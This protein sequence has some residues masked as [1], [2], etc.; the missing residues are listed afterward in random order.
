MTFFEQ[1]IERLKATQGDTHA[2]CAVAAEFLLL[3]QPEPEREQLRA[4]LDAAAVLRWFD[5]SFLGKML[6]IA[7]ADA[8]KRFDALKALPFVERYRRGEAD[9]RNVHE[10]TRLGWRKEL[11]RANCARFRFLSKQ[12]ADCFADDATPVGRIE[13]I[14]HLLCADPNRG[15]DELERLDRQWTGAARPEDRYALAGALSDLEQTRVVEGAA[16]VEVLLCVAQ[17]RNSRG[18]ESQ[19]E[20]PAL[21]ALALA[22]SVKRATSEARANC[23]LGDVLQAQ[24]KLA[25]AQAAFGECLAIS[26]RL[27]AQDPSNAGWQRDLAGAHS[28]VGGVLR[29]QGKLAEAQAALGEALAISRRLAAQDPSNAGWQ[30]ELAGTCAQVAQLEAKAGRHAAAFPL[31]EEASRIFGELLRKAPGFAEWAR[32]K[33]HVEVE[34]ALCRLAVNATK[35]PGST[36]S[37]DAW[38]PEKP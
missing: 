20:G 25:E 14:Y 5:A 9:L 19:L 28:K 29:D 23:L 12:A 24:G 16:R 27:A 4:A 36:T 18:E 33:A 34:L 26:R 6:G 15:A 2:Q 7:E 21:E 17:I 38:A 13:W 8:A 30:R 37:G 32:D 22:R 10:S 1:L 35:S 11:A 3:A 31:Y